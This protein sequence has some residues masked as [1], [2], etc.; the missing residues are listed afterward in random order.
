MK[1][2]KFGG[3]SLS[4]VERVRKVCE[5]VASDPD[6][7]FVVVSAPGR[8]FKGDVKVTDLL[9]ACADRK[10]KNED[11]E[12]E[13]TAVSERF[14]DLQKELGLPSSIAD[15][16]RANLREKANADMSHRERFIDGL[17]AAGEDNCAR[18][19]AAALT[20]GGLKASYVN[21]K[22]AGLLLSEE[23]GNAQIL[24]ESYDNL[25][26]LAEREEV[27]VFPGFFGYTVAG[28]VVTFPRGGSDIT[29]AV[30]AA[31][32]KADLYENFTDV[33]GVYSADPRMVPNA[34]PI[35]EITF[36]EMRE[37]SYTGFGVLHDEAI[38]PAVRAGI[39]IQVLNTNRPLEPGTTIVPEH[40]HTDS[41]VVGIASSEGFC[42]IYVE[43][44]LMNRE[45]GFGRKLLQ[46]FEEEGLSYEHVPSGIDNLSVILLDG[47][48][49][50]ETEKTVITAIKT[51]L[52]ADN[53]AIERGLALIMIVGEGMRYAVGMAAT[54]TKALA[55]SGVNIEMMNQGS[56]EISMMF[57]VKAVDRERAVQAL[58]GAFFE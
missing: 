12:A 55:E 15:E 43:K 45:I 1:V 56:S 37:L 52:G 13:L 51:R 26:K 6:R 46:V 14:A 50:S 20:A 44:Y 42:T 31:A 17:K 24:P 7:R 9:I 36:R 11:P 33:D 25:S 47:D 48:L 16:I 57:G 21:P 39:P 34:R 41:R 23:Y 8:R 58:Y 30:L 22:D 19:I 38:I 53:V 27:V 32:V 4:D 28:E 29:G 18:L 35:P 3:S 40:R 10:L 54:A 49:E 2:C 5:I